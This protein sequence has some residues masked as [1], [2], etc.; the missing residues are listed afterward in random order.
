ML[1]DKSLV[2]EKTRQNFRWSLVLTAL[3]LIVLGIILLLHPTRVMHLLSYLVGAMLT[4]YGLA[5]IIA[6]LRTKERHLTFEL[7]LGVVTA[8]M[9]I[10]TLVSPCS[11]FNA[12]QIVLGLVVIIDG[13]LGIKRALALRDVGAIWWMVQ[14]AVSIVAMVFGILLL[15]KKDI[16]G[17]ALFVVIGILLIFQGVSDLF[18]LLGM[19]IVGNRLWKK[20]DSAADTDDR[21]ED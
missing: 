20:L 13:F 15:I 14:L 3:A 21:F 8:A 18:G 10:F 7:L 2:L 9:G 6:F 19:N 4:I 5:N 11:V 16:F 12:I 1:T 17:T